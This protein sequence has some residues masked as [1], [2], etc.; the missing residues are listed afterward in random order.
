MNNFNLFT[1]AMIYEN[2]A[3]FYTDLTSVIN[4]LIDGTITSDVTKFI[5]K[6][7]WRR[8]KNSY[9]TFEYSDEGVNSFKDNLYNQVEEIT[10]DFFTY[11]SSNL[12]FYQ[13]F[14]DENNINKSFSK[15][16]YSEI[17]PINQNINQTATS[18]VFANGTTGQR[19][20]ET[21]SNGIGWYKA[22]QNYMTPSRKNDMLKSF[23][24]LFLPTQNLCIE[25]PKE[26]IINDL[27]TY[28][29][30][31]YNKATVDKTN[32]NPENIKK[33]VKILNVEGSYDNS[34]PTQEKTIT[35]TNNDTSYEIVPDDGYALSKATANVQIPTQIKSFSVTENQI[36]NIYPDEG[37]LLSSVVVD[38]SIPPTLTQEKTVS[39]TDNGQYVVSPDSGYGALSKVNVNVN[40]PTLKTQTKTLTYSSNGQYTIY[41]NAG[42]DAFTKVTVNINV[43]SIP[44]YTGFG[45]EISYDSQ[46]IIVSFTSLPVYGIFL[47]K[48]T[49]TYSDADYNDQSS[50]MY[51]LL[52]ITANPN[53][54]TMYNLYGFASTRYDN[55]N[56]SGYSNSTSFNIYASD[57]SSLI[58]EITNVTEVTL[59]Y[60][61]T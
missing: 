54:K 12:K 37:K 13:S 30:S 14:I 40:I 24:W 44:S 11:A 7:I 48:F 2:D 32:I 47:Y 6:P 29:T 38:I 61:E 16:L 31:G 60:S 10:F 23:K 20:I 39:Y 15:Q 36:L 9:T 26:L 34:T 17:S 3:A 50:T 22:I 59:V 25:E 8:F 58:N 27:K 35:C 41:P 1:L 19:I 56:H 49:L 55:I 5:F 28:L 43:S 51:L 53:L 33:G 46:S 52:R 4:E 42:Y 57:I 45:G 18:T 21:I